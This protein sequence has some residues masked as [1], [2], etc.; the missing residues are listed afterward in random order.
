MEGDV[1]GNQVRHEVELYGRGSSSDGTSLDGASLVNREIGERV[2]RTTYYGQEDGYG[3]DCPRLC[4]TASGEHFDPDGFTAA[5]NLF[6]L[7]TRLNVCWE[8]RCVRVRVNDRGGPAIE[9]DLSRAAF[10]ELA[11]LSRGVL[12]A[13]VEVVGHAHER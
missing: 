2:L 12:W 9:I 13:A 10:A 4:V 11:P 5:S 6:P 7:G 8:G 3:V 1:E